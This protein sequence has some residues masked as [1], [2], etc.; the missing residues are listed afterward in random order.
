MSKHH[1]LLV[2]RQHV[3]ASDERIKS[4]TLSNGF[5]SGEDFYT[6]KVLAVNGACFEMKIAE[7]D[8]LTNTIDILLDKV[9]LDVELWITSACPMH[10]LT[11]KPPS[12]I[13]GMLS[14]D[15]L[16]TYEVAKAAFYKHLA[17]LQST[18]QQVPPV[19]PVPNPLA[20]PVA[21]LGITVPTALKKAVPGIK[22]QAHCPVCEYGHISTG[23]CAMVLDVIVHLN[24]THEWTYSA[25]ADWLESLDV[26]LEF[27][28]KSN[29]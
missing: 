5:I 26:N 2:L 11:P 9:L 4:V 18:V 7:S 29:V 25:V 3:R 28:E 23:L 17:G 22:E 19:N 10:T 16:L 13:V 24:D 12:G 15:E 6:L 20:S 1:N 8:L 27:K 14:Q 21:S